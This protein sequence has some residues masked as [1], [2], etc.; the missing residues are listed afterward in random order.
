MHF[1][2]F[3]DICNQPSNQGVCRGMIPRY[4][5]NAISGQ[6]EIFNYGGCRGNANNFADEASCL[7]ACKK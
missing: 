6:C 7:A 1:Y 3:L 4:Y 2:F 5:Y